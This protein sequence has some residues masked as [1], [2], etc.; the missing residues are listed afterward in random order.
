MPEAWEMRGFQEKVEAIWRNVI[1]CKGRLI[2]YD[3]SCERVF[4]STRISKKYV[5]KE[6]KI[7]IMIFLSTNSKNTVIHIQNITT[8]DSI[9]LFL[10]FFIAFFEAFNI[11]QNLFLFFLSVQLIAIFGSLW[12]IFTTAQAQTFKQT[13]ENFCVV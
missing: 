10:E 5:I 4:K 13:L 7:F 9:L 6:L 2:V 11:V 1:K 8:K 3:M 12:K